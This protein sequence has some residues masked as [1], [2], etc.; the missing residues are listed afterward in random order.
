MSRTGRR[1]GAAGM[2]VR[3]PVPGRA[4]PFKVMATRMSGRPRRPDSP[5]LPRVIYFRTHERN[6]TG[7]SALHHTHSLP[8]LT[9]SGKGRNEE[10]SSS[11]QRWDGAGCVPGG[12]V[13]LLARVDPVFLQVERSRRMRLGGHSPF[14]P[15]PSVPLLFSFEPRPIIA[16]A[17]PDMGTTTRRGR[18][19]RRT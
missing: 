10:G 6:F 17:W 1:R 19:G 5:L 2:L 3:R 14:S 8:S 4:P 11:M 18:E 7:R 9:Q 15:S 12:Q 16:S 13:F